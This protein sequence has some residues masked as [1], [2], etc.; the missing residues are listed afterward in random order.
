MKYTLGTA[1]TVIKV[2]AHDP[3]TEGV[4]MSYC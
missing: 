4:S 2:T 3:S 1:L